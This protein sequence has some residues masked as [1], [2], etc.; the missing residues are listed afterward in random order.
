MPS[1]EGKTAHQLLEMHR[2]SRTAQVPAA[3]AAR[4][5]HTLQRPALALRL[6]SRLLAGRVAELGSFTL[7][8]SKAHEEFHG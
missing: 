7:C 1:C 4:F 6:Q 8:R 5:N 3:I 2:E